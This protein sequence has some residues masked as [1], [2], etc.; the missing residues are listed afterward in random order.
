MTGCVISKEF[1]PQF[2]LSCNCFD[3]HSLQG[4]IKSFVKTI[5]LHTGTIFN[6]N[7]CTVDDGVIK[8]CFIPNSFIISAFSLFLN[9]KPLSVVKTKGNPIHMK[10]CS[11]VQY[12]CPHVHGTE[13]KYTNLVEYTCNLMGL[14][15][16]C[17]NSFNPF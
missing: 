16:G 15:A 5:R 17:S 10:I 3:K 4:L 1:I 6:F 14:F 9:S 11:N 13:L 12:S 8:H 7:V 2:F